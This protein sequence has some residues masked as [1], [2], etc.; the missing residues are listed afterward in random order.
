MAKQ[1]GAFD[2]RHSSKKKGNIEIFMMYASYKQGRQ[3]EAGGLS[4]SKFCTTPELLERKVLPFY[5]II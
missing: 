4:W 2:R 3:P 1:V 5:F